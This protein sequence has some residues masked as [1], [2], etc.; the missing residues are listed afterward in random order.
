MHQLVVTRR[1]DAL[2]VPLLA[3]PF[4]VVLLGAARAAT[5][6]SPADRGFLAWDIQI[7]IQ[8]QDMGK[9][10]ERRARTKGVRDLGAM[11]VERHQQ[12]QKRLT[13]VAAGLGV[14][15]STTLS[16]EHL[17]VQRRYASIASS[18][19]DHAFVRH[20]I[21]DNRYFLAHFEPAARTRNPLLRSYCTEQI[22][23]LKQDQTRIVAL[24]AALD[25][26]R[27]K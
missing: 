16:E 17:R 25:A 6:T 10:A 12:T 23:Q 13:Q 1:F 7:E 8:Q 24:M 15:L 11:L 26:G 4:T 14:L 3:I 20:E 27:A 2:L 19:F 5:P 18:A 22:A 21:G 9:L